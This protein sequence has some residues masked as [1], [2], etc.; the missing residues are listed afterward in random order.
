MAAAAADGVGMFSLLIVAVFFAMMIAS[1]SGLIA[2]DWS[3]E[4]GIN[5]APPTWFKDDV[6]P[7]PPPAR[8]K[9]SRRTIPA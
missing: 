6:A 8:P 2:G 3:K 7:A 5:Y 9:S 1:R 4:I